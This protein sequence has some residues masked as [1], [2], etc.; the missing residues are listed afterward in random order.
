MKVDYEQFKQSLEEA[1]LTYSDRQI[2]QVLSEFGYD[3]FPDNGITEKGFR[4]LMKRVSEID[5]AESNLKI[6]E[7]KDLSSRVIKTY[8]NESRRIV[9]N[10]KILNERIMGVLRVG[11]FI[12]L[13]VLIG[14]GIMLRM[15]ESAEHTR[16]EK[17]V[18]EIA[19]TNNNFIGE[20]EEYSTLAKQFK[21]ITWER[22][23]LI[24]D[25]REEAIEEIKKNI[26]TTPK[27]ILESYIKKYG[28]SE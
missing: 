6:V 9:K 28:N 27:E 15:K 4:K 24:T 14:S 25:S 20:Y 8:K 19:D 22:Y 2:K 12:S 13:P 1:E 3:G 23:I 16:L 21:E 7:R 26:S 10:Y 18:Y 17:R 5:D 11:L